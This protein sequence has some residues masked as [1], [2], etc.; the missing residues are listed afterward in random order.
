MNARNPS[1]S[2][3][4]LPN[5]RPSDTSGAVGIGSGAADSSDWAS[6]GW[7]LPAPEAVNSLPHFSQVTTALSSAISRE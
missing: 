4:P 7:V 1:I 5:D 2:A 3:V 6:L